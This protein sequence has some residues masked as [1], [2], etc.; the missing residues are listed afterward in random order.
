MNTTTNT[1]A[2]PTGT[3]A[4]DPAATSVEVT[5]KKLGLITVVGKLKVASGSVI[6]SDGA[7]T[8]VE[9]VANASSYDSGNPKRDEHVASADFLDA[10]SHKTLT[11]RA[12]GGSADKVSGTVTIKGKRAPIT[13]T[14]SSVK[15]T[16]DTATFA[17]TATVDRNDLGIDKM[18]SFVIGR[19]LDISVKATARL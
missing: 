13:F 10:E 1:T 4:L 19:K 9:A 6:V 16:G 11:F 2:L 17:A 3:W 14:V 5:V 7:V 18:P 12:G 8:G 15:V